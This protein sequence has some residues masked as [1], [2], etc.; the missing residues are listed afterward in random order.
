MGWEGG[1][2]GACSPRLAG[3]PSSPRGPLAPP[4]PPP[5]PHPPPCRPCRPAARVGLLFRGQVHPCTGHAHHGRP[6]ARGLGQ[7]VWLQ[8]R[9]C[10]WGRGGAAGGGGC[11]E[12]A[13]LQVCA[14][15]GGCSRAWAQPSAPVALKGSNP[16]TRWRVA[17]AAPAAA[18]SARCGSKRR[19]SGP[20]F[21][22]PLTGW[23]ERTTSTGKWGG[24]QGARVCGFA[25]VGVA[26]GRALASL[27]R[28]PPR[29]APALASP[30]TPPPPKTHTPPA[31]PC[32]AGSGPRSSSTRW[33]RQR[34]TCRLR[35]RCAAPACL[36]QSWSMRR[37]SLPRRPRAAAAVT[38]PPRG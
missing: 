6:V 19:G 16:D 35:M 15:G 30:L 31:L 25:A 20:S 13:G 7:Q 1:R 22:R 33:T 28:P 38:S 11:S 3:R 37:S 2:W 26:R 27:A 21:S 14:R 9:G 10:G 36:R 34:G 23:W 29:P 18:R 17:A 32:L 12:R 4:H 24:A 8:V 5:H